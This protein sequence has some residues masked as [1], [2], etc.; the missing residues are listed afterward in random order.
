MFRWHVVS[1][2]F[3]RNVKQYFSGPLGYLF[4]VV[5]VTICAAMAFSPQFFADNQAT[6]DQLS[7]YFPLLLLFFIPAITMSVWSDEKR[8]GTD[9]IL[10]TLPA[11]DFDILMGKY[12]SV[13]AVYTVALLF[14]LT[15]VAVLEILGNPDVGVIVS[16]YIGY[17]LAG[18]ALLSVGMFA[19]SLTGSATVAFVLGSLFCAI[20]VLI[21]YYF[22]GWVGIERFGFSWNLRDF[23]LGLVPLGNIVYFVSLT[24]FMLYL[25]LIVISKRHWSRGQQFGLAGQYFVRAASL[26]V[27]LVSVAFLSNNA[28]SSVWSRVDLTA[29]RLFT[30]DQATVDT[31]EQAKADDRLVTVQ[32]FISEDVPRKYVNV[33]KQLEGLL[34]QYSEYGGNNVDVRFVDVQPDSDA[35]LEAQ[36]LGVEPEDDRSEIGGKT[37]EQQVYLGATVSSSLGDVTLPFINDDASI[38][39]ELSRSLASTVDKSKQI[40]LGILDTDAHFGGPE[41]EGRRIP[42]SYARTL[43]ELEKQFKLKQIGAD[44]LGS[45][46]PAEGEDELKTEKEKAVKKTVKKAPDVLLV[47]DPSS[48]DEP[49]MANLIAYIKA[50]NPTI[51]L[52]DPLP[53][54]W[55]FQNPVSIGVLNAPNQPRVGSQSPYSQILASSQMPKSDGGSAAK[56][57]KAIGVKWNSGAAAWGVDDPHPGFKPTWPEYIGTRW[58]EYYGPQDKAFVFVRNRGDNNAFAANQAISS[59]LK[60]LLMFYPGS[61]SKSAD[62]TY[63]FT[64]LVSLGTQSGST[65]WDRLTKTPVQTSQLLDPRTGRITKQTQPATSQITMD[66]LKV[67]EPFP[68]TRLDEEEKVVAARVTGGGEDQIDVVLIA[69]MDFVSDLYFTQQ[70]AL[71]QKLDNLSLLQNSIDILAG[72]EDFVAL[73][74]RRA[75]PRTLE[76]LESVIEEFR[77][78]RAQKQESAEKEMLSE[79]EKEQKKLQDANKEIQQDANIGFFEKLQRTSQEASDSQRRF[80]LKKKRLDRDLKQTIAKLDTRES[81]QISGLENK[82]R[83]LSILSA[84]LPALFLGI[85]V[86]WF[87]KVNEE[88]GIS[89]NRRV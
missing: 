3:G 59:G 55:T 37:V 28:I 16:T 78:E 87:R 19:S 6:L 64:P 80:D 15:Q 32:A 4:I 89:E 54:F 33:K 25:N 88:K 40:T 79:L 27:A 12:L 76:K 85:L 8:Q 72:N 43:E 60:E 73:R 61:V 44:E 17:W 29:E 67:L 57:M 81:Q 46:V 36:Q 21:G 74:N 10:F 77:A 26:G 49:S 42:W 83:Y 63:D 68:S 47:A 39:Y 7:L 38:E 9:S 53:F 71:G 14:S 69:D 22:T 66:P 65:P 2:V 75:T 35:A 13:A 52:T 5:F 56:L 41:I 82:A 23:T 11:S 58:P 84:P 31:L 86:L 48:L 62:S 50:G 30:L 45:Y 18:L 20:P 24:V 51:L 1:A 70:E 34:R